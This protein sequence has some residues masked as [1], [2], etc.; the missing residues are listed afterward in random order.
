V[1]VTFISEAEG[2]GAEWRGASHP[3]AWNGG[4]VEV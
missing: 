3:M 1:K 2:K 4:L